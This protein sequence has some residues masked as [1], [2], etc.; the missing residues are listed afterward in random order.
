MQKTTRAAYGLRS[1]EDFAALKS[2]VHSLAPISR[3]LVT[4]IY[5]CVVSSYPR[6]ALSAILPMALY[7]VLI[8][9]LTGIPARS[10]FFKALPALPFIVL[11][12]LFNPI[13]DKTP[14][15]I[16]GVSVAGGWISFA[17]LALKGVFAVL[18][19]LLL[20][21]TSG[22]DGVASAL[23]ALRV[24]R[25]LVLQILLTYRYITVL[26][27]EASRAVTAYSLRAPGHKGIRPKVWGP[28]AGQMLLRTFDRAGRIYNAML[29]R[30]FKGEYITGKDPRLRLRDVFYILAFC[31]FFAVCRFVDIPWLIGA[32]INKL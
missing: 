8:F 20:A 29:L 19:A 10:I 25:A 30:G 3:L 22:M 11:V 13:L 23:R 2:P 16:Y 32:A 28:L 7:P 9:S 4:L 27:G 15:E 1:V 18:A 24:P 12:G 6:Y 26:L 17:V 14:M 5:I 31:A 21:A